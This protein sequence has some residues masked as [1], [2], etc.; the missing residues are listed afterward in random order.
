LKPPAAGRVGCNGLLARLPLPAAPIAKLKD[1]L[2]RFVM[3]VRLR[4]CSD[5]NV[6]YRPADPR[7]NEY[8]A[9]AEQVPHKPVHC[10]LLGCAE[11]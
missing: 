4:I 10:K 7:Y 6:A 3:E 1:F 8:A 5:S 9:I 11:F 2:I